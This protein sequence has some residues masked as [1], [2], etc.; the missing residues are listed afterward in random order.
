MN[1]QREQFLRELGYTDK[2]IAYILEEKNIGELE[3]PSITARHQGR[4]GDIMVLQLAIDRSSGVIR[5]ARFR[6]T[7]CAGLQAAGSA[8]TDM[9]RG[10]HI[11]D[12]S[13]IEDRDIIDFL[14]GSFPD[15]KLDC[16]ELA[17]D[18]LRKT[19]EEYNRQVSS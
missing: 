7:G 18:T 17:R 11:D 15:F 2:A 3:N 12:A 1:A 4:C 19:I 6:M 8:V 10:M 13:K 16:V 14:G 9:I 5:D